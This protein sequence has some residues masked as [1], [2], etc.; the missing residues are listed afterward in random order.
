MPMQGQQRN[1][2]L[3]VVAVV[4]MGFAGFMFF[5]NSGQGEI[6]SDFSIH[7]AC[8]ACKQEVDASYKA[9]ERLPAVC[10]SCGQRAVYSW[11]YCFDCKRRFVPRPEPAPD[12]GPP[13]MPI[14]PACTACGSSRTGALYPNDPEQQPIGDAELPKWP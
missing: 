6:P 3:G 14:V 9:G 8:L 11:L 7:G 2:I 10:P 1:L 13:R 12:G 4:L 5:R